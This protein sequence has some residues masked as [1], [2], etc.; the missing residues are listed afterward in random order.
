ML[1]AAKVLAAAGIDLLEGPA[2]I[3]AAKAELAAQTR[4]APYVSP[5]APGQKA[6]TY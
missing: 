6:K 3:A 2:A 1:V 4:G 5:L